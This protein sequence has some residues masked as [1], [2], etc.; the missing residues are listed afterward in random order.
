MGQVYEGKFNFDC[1]F[2]D[3]KT[4]RDERRVFS[5]NYVNYIEREDCKSIPAVSLS[6]LI[7]P[8]VEDGVFSGPPPSV[9][10]FFVG[11]L[12]KDKYLEIENED[13]LLESIL[14]YDRNISQKAGIIDPS[15]ENSFGIGEMA[16]TDSGK[17]IVRPFHIYFQGERSSGNR[18]LYLLLTYSDLKKLLGFLTFSYKDVSINSAR[19]WFKNKLD[20][21]KN[22]PNQLAVLY[23]FLP[24]EFVEDLGFNANKFKSEMKRLADDNHF[25]AIRSLMKLWMLTGDIENMFTFFNDT[26]I[27]Y[28]IYIK[29][30][31]DYSSGEELA[32]YIG[33]L[34]QLYELYKVNHKI[35]KAQFRM[36]EAGE[37][38]FEVH[39]SGTNPSNGG[40]D[41]TPVMD[42]RTYEE[43]YEKGDLFTKVTPR[44]GYLQAVQL[45]PLETFQY[46]VLV[47]KSQLDEDELIYGEIRGDNVLFK[48]EIP[49]IYFMY[50]YEELYKSY[51]NKGR[52]EFA[53]NALLSIANIGI[54]KAIA[55]PTSKL[56]FRFALTEVVFESLNKAINNPLVVSQLEQSQVG[57]NFLYIW[58]NYVAPAGNAVFII[59]GFAELLISLSRS[60]FVLKALK[61]SGDPDI[62][63]HLAKLSDKIVDFKRVAEGAE[64]IRGRYLGQVLEAA[65]I[66]AVKNYLK[67][68]NV[69]IQIGSG[70]GAFEVAGYFAK[71]G[72][73]LKMPDSAAAMFITDGKNWK[74]V[75]RESATTYELLHEM[76]H[77]RQC[78]SIGKMKYLKYTAS[79]PMERTILRERYVFDKMMQHRKYINREE[80]E[81]AKRYMNRVYKDGELYGL[82]PNNVDFD[83]IISSIPKKRQPVSIDK[84]LKLK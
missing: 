27:V 44:K 18:A 71:N 4:A 59:H 7:N 82:S 52:V 42:I 38:F 79:T 11:K 43:Y 19:E 2:N 61:K 70:T 22:S 20:V 81:H 23:E 1:F 33:L 36:P 31:K 9:E 14:V 60:K 75:L 83:F 51:I 78:K 66:D 72:D 55:A 62:E 6:P 25:K 32:E 54:A 45:Q 47:P 16:Y 46:Y 74:L 40:K 10:N 5:F 39:P 3:L 26:S 29:N 80:L 77:F 65:D 37:F 30:D 84:I 49:A 13:G 24:L 64:I 12:F 56:V 17:A 28:I 34:F 50:N 53:I 69:D 41:Y 67:K 73:V 21:H 68:Y 48:P 63:K 76:M 58:N 15:L 57:N 8:P 35:P